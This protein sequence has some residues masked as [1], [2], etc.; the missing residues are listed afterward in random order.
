MY[1]IFFIPFSVD[2]FQVLAVVSKQCAV[3]T[4]VNASF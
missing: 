1:H 4:G 2:G 3:N